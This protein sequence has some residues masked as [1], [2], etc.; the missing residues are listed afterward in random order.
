MKA[1][2]KGVAIMSKPPNS[3]TDRTIE[4]VS[5]ALSVVSNDLDPDA[6]DGEL[7][8]ELRP[9]VVFERVRSALNSAKSNEDIKSFIDGL[10]VANQSIAEQVRNHSS[11]ALALCHECEHLIKKGDLEAALSTA[12]EAR[13][14]AGIA[15]YIAAPGVAESLRLARELESQ[16]GREHVKKNS[17]HTSCAAFKAWADDQ[18]SDGFKPFKVSQIKA[19]PGFNSAWAKTDNTI[20]KWWKTVPG[21]SALL[22]GV[23]K[24]PCK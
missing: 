10:S 1:H 19:R 14:Y 22:R 16:R 13:E 7:C 8:R 20:R 18:V 6:L 24:T 5:L 21:A 4:L 3:P 15:F 9:Q 23:Q 17:K 12:L 11:I 2:A